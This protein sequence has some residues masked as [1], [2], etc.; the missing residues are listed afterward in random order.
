MPVVGTEAGKRRPGRPRSEKSRRAI[1]AAAAEL[2]QERPLSEIS[3]D[4]VAERAGASKATIYRWWPSKELLALDA[5]FSD[6][7][8]PLPEDI[9]RGSLREDLRALMLPWVRRLLSAPYGRVV[10]A[11][12]VELHSDAE[13]L[14]AWQTRFVGPRRAPGR[15]AFERA[16]ARGEIAAETDI[17]LALDMLYG[18]IYHRLLNLHQPLD[19]RFVGAVVDG[20]L[21]AVGA[22]TER[23]A[24]SPGVHAGRHR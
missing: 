22:N 17:E 9:D 4:A 10:A 18:P 5:M 2:L 24:G 16:A 15:S 12:T 1:L 3:M 20:V 8:S 6:W 11:L 23:V 14:E 19:E 13:L 21:A 7:E